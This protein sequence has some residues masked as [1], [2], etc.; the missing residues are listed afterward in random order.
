MAGINE[1]RSKHATQKSGKRCRLF[2]IIKSQALERTLARQVFPVYILVGPCIFLSQWGYA[3]IARAVE[4]IHPDYSR[5][6]AE[7][8]GIEDW[9][10]TIDQLQT[11][12]MFSSA[13]IYDTYFDK[14][15]LDAGS[16]KL[17]IAYIDAPNTVNT[18]I[19]RAPHLSIRALHSF[20]NHRNI[21]IVQLTSPEGRDLR[22]MVIQRFTEKDIL[23]QPAVVDL[24][25][26][27]TQGSI[28]AIWQSIERIG[29]IA[30][31]GVALTPDAVIPYI[32]GSQ[33]EEAFILS[34]YFLERSTQNAIQHLRNLEKAQMVLALWILTEDIR[35]C[36]ALYDVYDT[37]QY[38]SKCESLGIWKSKTAL[39]QCALKRA[40]LSTLYACF[41]QVKSIEI[42][43]KTGDSKTVLYDVENMIMLFH[44]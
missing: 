24:M 8:A 7:L 23:V 27:K 39:Y 2:M 30:E 12:S 5:I 4:K 25:L 36:I 32:Y 16:Q 13:R 9:R 10:D 31:E 17:C 42:G 41:N 20:S 34:T 43:L 29:H 19:I 40:T 28:G 6:S 21:G 14:K 37:P 22:D 44:G 38:M 26:E 11:Y 1:Q 18:W 3:H 35:R 33:D 15:T